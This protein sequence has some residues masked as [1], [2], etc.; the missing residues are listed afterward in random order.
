MLQE[1]AIAAVVATGCC[2]ALLAR[3][4]SRTRT[5]LARA[6]GEARA[7][8]ETASSRQ[9]DLQ[10]QQELV[11]GFVQVELPTLLANQPVA[12]FGFDA[13]GRPAVHAFS[14]L[15]ASARHQIHG[16][17]SGLNHQMDNDRSWQGGWAHYLG[18][19]L[20]MYAQA[21]D[22]ALEDVACGRPPAGRG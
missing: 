3:A 1:A 12:E 21:L 7:A 2:A 4:L 15:L 18:A 5:A 10:V 14:A 6:T 22:I 9:A 17:I 20:D 16:A 8:Q 13:P 11:R 19:V